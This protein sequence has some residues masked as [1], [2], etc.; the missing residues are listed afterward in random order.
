MSL[1]FFLNPHRLGIEGDGPE[2]ALS[3]HPNL[4]GRV[5][6]FESGQEGV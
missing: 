5:R 3:V 2:F 6:V 1:S 4:C